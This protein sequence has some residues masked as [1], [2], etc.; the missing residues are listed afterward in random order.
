MKELINAVESL[1]AKATEE[2]AHQRAGLSEESSLR[3]PLDRTGAFWRHR[4]GWASNNY[5]LPSHACK[6][7]GTQTWQKEKET[8]YRCSNFT[9]I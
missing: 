6:T 8:L 2:L 5:M 4:E 3:K 9:R 1:R 7:K